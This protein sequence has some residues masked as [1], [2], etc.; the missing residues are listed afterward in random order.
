[1]PEVPFVEFPPDHSTR[2]IGFA[3]L[4]NKCGG[5]RGFSALRSHG[6]PGRSPRGYLYA[7]T[8]LCFH[9]AFGVCCF[10]F[11]S[12]ALACIMF[13][14]QIHCYMP[15][16]C[17]ACRTL[18]L[19]FPVSSSCIACWTNRVSALVEDNATAAAD[20]YPILCW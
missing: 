5:R 18:I 9:A 13:F 4:Q 14:P 6:S 20:F 8:S 2:G 7:C 10:P 15:G 12:I 11:A 3:S 17:D 16:T 1:M 19:P